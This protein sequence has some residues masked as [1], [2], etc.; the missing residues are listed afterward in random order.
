MKNAAF[1]LL[2]IFIYSISATEYSCDPALACG[3]SKAST[4]VTS[5]IV[6]GETS[7]KDAWG[8]MISVHTPDR[9]LCG[10]S[11]LSSEYAVTAASCVTR[12]Q[13]TQSTL[14][15]QA[16]TNHLNTTF[17]NTAQR[18]TVTKII[19]PPDHDSNP[20]TNNIAIIQ[21]SP[22]TIPSNSE[23]AF[24]CLP[25]SNEDPFQIKDNLVAL[26]WGDTNEYSNSVSN[27]L[28]Q[29]TLQT[30]SST[31]VPCLRS[32]LID[33]DLQFCAGDIS[34]RKG[35]LLLFRSSS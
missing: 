27:S 19:L 29:V 32:G 22:L 1:S 33:S 4:I 11:L 30:Y 3:C 34:G 6:G 16:G 17:Q 26:G 12:F 15:I 23:L 9:F 20:I 14:L 5:R 8:W 18:R 7:A 31:S 10:A 2:F 28:Q 35:E 21:F 25:E 13:A 24:I